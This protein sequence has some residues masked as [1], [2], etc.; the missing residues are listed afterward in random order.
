MYTFTTQEVGASK[1]DHTVSISAE[2]KNDAW[3]T[4]TY[5]YFSKGYDRMSI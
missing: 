1:A 4:N 3:N 2:L 5:A